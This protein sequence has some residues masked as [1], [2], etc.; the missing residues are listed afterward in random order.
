VPST[1]KHSAVSLSFSRLGP[2]R[3]AAPTDGAFVRD[4]AL[5]LI[6]GA[7]HSVGA[8]IMTGVLVCS[9]ST[10]RRFF[11]APAA[12]GAGKAVARTRGEAPKH[13]AC[14]ASVAPG[15]PKGRALGPGAGVELPGRGCCNKPAEVKR[16][17]GQRR[18]GTFPCRQ[19][20]IFWIKESRRKAPLLT[21]FRLVQIYN[22]SIL[23]GKFN[24]SSTGR[25][26]RTTLEYSEIMMEDS[27]GHVHAHASSMLPG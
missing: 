8:G 17:C 23:G 1:A 27:Q 25:L 13:N 12:A 3:W 11:S 5:P 19:I 15:V 20:R 22:M 6:R 24:V 16:R 2:R 9:R 10:L 14:A 18:Y 7:E 4:L 26:H 21:V